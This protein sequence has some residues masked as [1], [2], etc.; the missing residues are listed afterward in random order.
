MASCARSIH[1]STVSPCVI[2]PG[3]AGTVTV[4]PPTSVSGSRIMVYFLIITNSSTVVRGT[5]R[6]CFYCEDY[7]SLHKCLSNQQTQIVGLTAIT[8]PSSSSKTPPTTSSLPH[9]P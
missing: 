1:C 2:H 3:N 9:N 7:I 8:N 4:Y 5:L 6:G